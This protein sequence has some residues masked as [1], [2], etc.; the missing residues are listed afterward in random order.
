[1][2]WKILAKGCPTESCWF[3]HITA[4]A[5]GLAPGSYESYLRKE[6]TLTPAGEDKPTGSARY[7]DG[8]RG[9]RGGVVGSIC[10]GYIQLPIK[11]Y[12]NLLSLSRNGPRCWCAGMIGLLAV[13][14]GIWSGETEGVK[15]IGHS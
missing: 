11:T 4:L 6:E 3:R 1:M 7:C 13:V 8:P 10:Y 14:G 15:I 12:E 2:S 5:V 9:T